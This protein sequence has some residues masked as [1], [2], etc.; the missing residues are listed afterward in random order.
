MSGFFSKLFGAGDAKQAATVFE[1]ETYKGFVIAPQPKANGGQ[2]NIAGSIRKEGEQDGPS[3][4]FIRADTF[5]SVEEAVRYTLIKA[6]Q[7]I[8]QQG[9]RLLK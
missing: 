2:F 5:T 1:T 3:H 6:R 7:I 8:D 9:E 4:D